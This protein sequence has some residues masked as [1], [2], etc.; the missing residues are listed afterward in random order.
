MLGFLSL[1]NV[2]PPLAGTLPV[3]TPHILQAELWWQDE[4]SL[5]KA[6]RDAERMSS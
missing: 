2:T 6:A 1:A 3:P 5:P 4:G